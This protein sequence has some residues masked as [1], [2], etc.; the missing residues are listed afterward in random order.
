VNDFALEFSRKSGKESL[1]Q[2]LERTGVVGITNV[3]TRML[4]R[5]IRSKGAMNAIISSEL[6]PEQLK[7]E[8]KRC[9]PWMASSSRQK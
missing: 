2:Y 7:E 6:S 1:Q 3:D 8:I 5:Y 4:V 9:L